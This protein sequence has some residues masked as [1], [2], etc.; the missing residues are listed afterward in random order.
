MKYS[1]TNIS[2]NNCPWKDSLLLKVPKRKGQVTPWPW[3]GSHGEAPASVRR[4]RKGVK[5]G[6]S[7]YCGFH[8]K[9]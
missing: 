1:K 2:Q 6:K 3:Q 5:V 8:G 7:I 4:Q 9:E